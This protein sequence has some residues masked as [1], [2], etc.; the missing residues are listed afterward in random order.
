MY[1]CTKNLP[2]SQTAKSAGIISTYSKKECYRWNKSRGEGT[3]SALWIDI[4]YIE[5]KTNSTYKQYI[6][7]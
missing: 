1:T 6:I 2:S 4:F 5:I 3:E 7:L